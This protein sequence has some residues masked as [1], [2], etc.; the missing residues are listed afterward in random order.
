MKS[1]LAL[2]G[3]T[4]LLMSFAIPAKA[5]L[6]TYTDPMVFS[7]VAPNLT[8]E[9][10]SGTLI[11]PN[12]STGCSA[13]INSTT[14]SACFALGGVASGFSINAY[15]TD[16]NTPNDGTVVLTPTSFGVT[17]ISVG[18]TTFTN[19]TV[20]DFILPNSAVGFDLVT[21]NGIETLVVEVFDGTGTS[22]GTTNVTGSDSG[23][24]FGAT[25][26]EGI[27]RITLTGAGNEAELIANLRFGVFNPAGIPTI[28]TMGMFVLIFLLVITSIVVTRRKNNF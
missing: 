10:F 12:T 2:T 6:T 11:A 26:P 1:K 4:V 14:A 17:N 13:A 8:T 20:I 21:P 9:D 18:A 23:T 7:N 22:L 19:N 5:A 28:T 16:P 27:S 25:A 24:F 15:T 3:L